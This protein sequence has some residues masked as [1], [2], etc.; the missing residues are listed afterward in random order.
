M[1]RLLL[2]LFLP[3]LS[4]SQTRYLDD[5]FINVTVTSDVE[6]AQN[7]SILP[8][9]L[10]GGVN[11]PALMPI[12]CDIYEPTGDSLTDRPVI[13]LAHT[14]SFLPP[15]I[16]GQPTGSKLDSSIVQQCMRWA[17]K[18]Y[19]AV[20]MNYRLGWNPT[21][22]DQDVRTQPYYK[23]LTEEY[24]MPKQWFVI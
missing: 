4:F 5:V 10:S 6:Y 15:V 18:G 21:S 1:K 11:P 16:N 23:Q 2:F 22:T 17:R 12:L 20:A 24:K 13:V 19:V 3:L 8:A 14:G 9:I 7:I